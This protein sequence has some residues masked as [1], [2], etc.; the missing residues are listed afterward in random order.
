MSSVWTGIHSVFRSL[1][2]S[3]CIDNN[4]ETKCVVYLNL[5]QTDRLQLPDAQFIVFED[6]IWTVSHSSQSWNVQ[7]EVEWWKKYKTTYSFILALYES[8]AEDKKPILISVLWSQKEKKEATKKILTQ[9]KK[10]HFND[11]Y[12]FAHVSIID[13]YP[14]ADH[15]HNPGFFGLW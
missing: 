11:L 2:G 5:N 10:F 3:L 9:H 15:T 4:L 7:P 1:P 8:N 14:T 13:S 6:T 12:V